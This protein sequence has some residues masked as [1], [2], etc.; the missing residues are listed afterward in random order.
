[1]KIIN[2]KLFIIGLLLLLIGFIL[3]MIQN[4]YYNYIDVNDVLVD[5][6]FLPVESFCILFGSIAIFLNFIWY[7]YKRK[8]KK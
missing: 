6:I 8:T 1:M 3:T 4:K 5:S 7:F 2:T